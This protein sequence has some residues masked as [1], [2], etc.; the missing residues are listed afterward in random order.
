MRRDRR[1]SDRQGRQPEE[2][3]EATAGKAIKKKYTVNAIILRSFATV[4][5]CYY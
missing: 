1:D 3:K 2:F 4:K 5:T